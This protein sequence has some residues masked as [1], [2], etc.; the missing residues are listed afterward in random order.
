MTTEVLVIVIVV[1]IAIM[2][3]GYLLKYRFK[4]KDNNESGR[5]A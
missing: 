5:N 4:K 3:L 1:T 2:V